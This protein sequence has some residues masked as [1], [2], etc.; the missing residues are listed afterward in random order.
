MFLRRSISNYLFPGAITRTFEIPYIT[1]WPSVSPVNWAET[2]FWCQ[3]SQFCCTHPINHPITHSSAIRSC[4]AV[5]CYMLEC[6]VS[7]SKLLG[8]KTF[9]FFGW[10]RKKYRIANIL[11]SET[12]NQFFVKFGIN[13]GIRFEAFQFVW[14][15]RIQHRIS[16]WYLKSLGFGT[17]HILGF[18]THWLAPYYYYTVVT[19]QYKLVVFIQDIHDFEFIPQL[20]HCQGWLSLQKVHPKGE[21][22]IST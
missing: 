14:W 21:G 15:F 7:V 18:I 8:F 5:S 1:V 9:P 4:K 19:L 3:L 12:R 13:M 10:Y 6:D 11:L 20:S 22:G 17:V 16:K 2:R